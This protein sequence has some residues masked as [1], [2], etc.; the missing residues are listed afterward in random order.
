MNFQHLEWLFPVVL[1]LHNTEEAI[2]LPD[3]AKRVS[4]WKAPVSSGVFRF[5]V[6]ILTLLACAVTWLS[7]R[8]GRQSVWTCLAFGCMVVTLANALVPHLALT[9]ARRSYMPGV[10]TAVALNLPVL[11]LL[12]AM[13]LR[14]GFVTGGKAAAY[15]IGVA[16][17]VVAAIP[18][19]FKMGRALNL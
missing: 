6:A 14:E 17:L 1:T 12:V 18:A 16:G 9:L 3:W 2:W 11:T 10:A 19:L 5:A 4:F 7:E 13:A 8:S 15:S